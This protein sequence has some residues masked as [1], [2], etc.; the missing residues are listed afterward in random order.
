MTSKFET[1]LKN[2]FGKIAK[3]LT[4]PSNAREIEPIGLEAVKLIVKRTR[5]GY[6][7]AKN[8]G[9]RFR[10]APLSPAYVNQRRKSRLSKF[11]RP[12]KSNLSRTGEMLSSVD[13]IRISRGDIFVGPTGIRSTGLK[14]SELAKFQEDRKNRKFNYISDKEFNQLRRIYRKSF[15][16]LLRKRRLLR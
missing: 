7:V 16:D 12:K 3:E 8:G 6:G 11:A 13:V 5:L 14:N 15:G 10:L 1:S 2:I 4:N 9:R